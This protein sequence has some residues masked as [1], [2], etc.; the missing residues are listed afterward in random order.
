MKAW[1]RRG[2][3]RYLFIRRRNVPLSLTYRYER[4][5]QCRAHQ[6][7]QTFL[8]IFTAMR[9]KRRN[10]LQHLRSLCYERHITRRLTAARLRHLHGAVEEDKQIAASAAA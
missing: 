3:L 10:Y 1:R 5:H 8:Y 4:C 6:Q 7:K 9:L 2:A